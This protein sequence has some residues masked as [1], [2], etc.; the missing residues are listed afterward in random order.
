M[1]PISYALS[2][3]RNTEWGDPERLE[4]VLDRWL[5]YYQRIGITRLRFGAIILRRCPERANWFRADEF[6]QY[7]RNGSC[8]GQIEGIF[9]AETFFASLDNEKR[10][11]DFSLELVPDHCLEYE[12]QAENGV[13]HARGARLKH[14]RG[15][16]CSSDIDQN[17]TSLLAGC[18]GKRIFREQVVEL[19]GKLNR[20]HEEIAPECIRVVRDLMRWGFLRLSD[21]AS[22]QELDQ[23]RLE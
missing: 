4:Q 12:L 6:P 19:A 17:V 20:G 21:D 3:L 8:G 14:N 5:E 16:E 10:L 18:T 15:F 7:R 2:M 9:A 1:D 11:L 23:N 13:W 22:T